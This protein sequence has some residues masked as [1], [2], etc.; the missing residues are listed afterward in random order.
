MENKCIHAHLSLTGRYFIKLPDVT[1]IELK[2][3]NCMIDTW[4]GNNHFIN[5]KLRLTRGPGA[6]QTVGLYL[7]LPVGAL[8][9]QVGPLGVCGCQ[10]KAVQH[11]CFAQTTCQRRAALERW[12]RTRETKD[13]FIHPISFRAEQ[14]G[15]GEH[16]HSVI[17]ELMTHTSPVCRVQLLKTGMQTC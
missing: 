14:K 6:P 2:W 7:G 3:K 15:F 5:V 9:H 12:P 10:L 17:C 13:T 4:L 11:W 16:E 8:S 1:G